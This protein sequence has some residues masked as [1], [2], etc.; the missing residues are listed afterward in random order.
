MLP[1]LTL[2]ASL[3]EM[4][5]ALRPCFTAPG[6]VT[7][8]GLVAGLAGRVR[9]RTVVGM[10][11]GGCL[12]HL[13][14]HDRAHYFFAR[15]RWELDQLGLAV[16]Q[17]VVLLLVPP[18]ADLRVA[19]DDSVFRRSGRKVHGAGW[20]HDGSSPSGNKLSYGNCFVA[21]AILVDL[22]FCSRRVGLPVLAR[23]H[24]PGKGAGEAL[25]RYAEAVTGVRREPSGEEV[26]G[27]RLTGIPVHLARLSAARRARQVLRAAEGAAATA[28]IELGASYPTIA[29]AADAARQTAWKLYRPR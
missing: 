25:W 17:L 26:P 11:L 10:L 5:S 12:Q 3:L 7:F 6:F 19:V 1:S 15:A 13:W 14:P 29:D 8:C 24:L 27:G 22:P 21:A 23:L 28:A 9:R 16:A 20:Q 2:P 4:L 18:G